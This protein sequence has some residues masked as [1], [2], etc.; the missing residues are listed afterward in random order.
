ML[1]AVFLRCAW[2]QGTPCLSS[3]HLLSVV[4]REDPQRQPCWPESAGVSGELR[5]VL[6][7]LSEFF[8]ANVP[9][10]NEDEG[11]AG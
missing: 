10:H 4:V 6:Q 5:R 9:T 3:P 2:R 7:E 8:Q 11:S 1:E